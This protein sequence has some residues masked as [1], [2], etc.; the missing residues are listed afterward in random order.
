MFS[1]LSSFEQKLVQFREHWF[2]QCLYVEFQGGMDA[3]GL[4]GE[5]MN[6]RATSCQNKT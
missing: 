1:S 6:R 3:A 5:F 4:A 2:G